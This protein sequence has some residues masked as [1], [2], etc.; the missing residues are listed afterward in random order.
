MFKLIKFLI[1][2]VIGLAL[3]ALI[4]TK[5]VPSS[6]DGLKKEASLL[7]GINAQ[8]YETTINKPHNP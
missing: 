2:F 5:F 6:L 3:L 8:N 1:S 7:T 4:P